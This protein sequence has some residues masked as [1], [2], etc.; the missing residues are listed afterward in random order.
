MK[1]F[2]IHTSDENCEVLDKAKEKSKE[3]EEQDSK[4]EQNGKGLKRPIRK[5]MSQLALPSVTTA[6][7]SLRIV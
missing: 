5:K 6:A 7:P 1:K 4:L 3:Q 2:N